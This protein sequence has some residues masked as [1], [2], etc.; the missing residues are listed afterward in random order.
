MAAL[1]FLS[2][3]GEMG[4]L[5]RAFD[6]T[7][8]PLGPPAKWPQSL[9]TMVRTM[10]TTR[11]PVFIFWGTQSIS[12]YND[13]YRATLPPDRHPWALG[14]PG[15]EVW[16]EIWDVIG[17]QIAQVLSGGDATWNEN[18]KLWLTRNGQKVETYWTYSYGPI[19]DDNA[20]NGVGGVLV[21]VSET[22]EQVQAEIRY[23]ELNSH[24]EQE[25]ER[26]GRDRDR[27][28]AHSRDLLVILDPS[29]II[30]DV[31]PICLQ[32]LG[33]TPEEMVGRNCVDFLH[34]EDVRKT[35]D[36]LLIAASQQLDSFEN[37]Y[38]HKNGSTVCLSWVAFPQDDLI[39]AAARNV[40]REREAAEALV[41][42]ETA[43][44]QSQKMEAVGQLTGGI[45]HDFNNL[46]TGIS[47][48][49]E[50]MSVRIAQGRP[51]EIDRYVLAAQG[52][53][54]RAAALTH[55]LLAFSRRQT[56]D[57]KPVNVNRII[58]NM[59]ELLR[60]T[61]SLDVYIEVVGAADLWTTIVDPGQ[62]E[63]SLLNLCINARDAMPDGGRITIETGNKW[64]DTRT[65][66]S[67]D[68]PPG[69]YVSLCVTDSGIGMDSDT[70][71][72]AFDPFFTTK[73]IGVG[74][75]L[76]L[77]MVYGFVR[78]SG[79]QVRIYSELGRGTTV[80]MYFPRHHG[81]AVGDEDED[82]MCKE[83]P[84]VATNKTVLLVDDE[85]VIRMLV[86]EMLT[87]AG[88]NVLE[89]GDGAEAIKTLQ[90]DVAID[91]LVTDVGLPG[92]LNG[93][94]VADAARGVRPELKVVFITGY[95]ENAV[96][97]N[98]H[99]DPGMEIV[100]KPF[101][102]AVLLAKVQELLNKG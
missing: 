39:Y 99:L 85:P 36:T 21:L 48:S 9:K 75:G 55:R 51:N 46:L 44:R 92:Q 47:G 1:D 54:K 19:G 97:G 80:C 56:L 64:I 69:Q 59:F 84:I 6:W 25:V 88:F 7:K 94:Q 91:L 2:G 5:I 72:R 28:W 17:P 37:R 53:A 67:I 61:I 71:A 13:A 8:T 29:G 52:A 42:A 23:H 4:S 45:A 22:T 70:I 66:Q 15:R 35:K 86:V 26:R 58:T 50:V 60:R 90:S 95:A 100:T 11:H 32:M 34:P 102:I 89:A 87:D 62:L 41:R 20:P 3:G 83:V 73:P 33:F 31:N 40:T 49:L 98:G 43:L 101:D 12:L 81:L 68:L 27:I 10:L 77:S 14:R 18:Q 82:S 93:R 79:G 74:T 30:K 65:A 24:L 38:L 78:Q 96:V 76:G 57:P 63:N 16:E